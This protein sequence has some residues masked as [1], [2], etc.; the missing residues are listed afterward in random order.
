[1]AERIVKLKMELPLT[2]DLFIHVL[3][4]Y[5]VPT[6]VLQSLIKSYIFFPICIF[7]VFS[8]KRSYKVLYLM[9]KKVSESRYVVLTLNPNYLN[10]SLMM[11][12]FTNLKF[13]FLKFEHSNLI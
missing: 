12:Y 11:N 4:G 9:V 8:F 2:S 13:V 6:Q 7:W 3:L 5:R 10:Q 1:M